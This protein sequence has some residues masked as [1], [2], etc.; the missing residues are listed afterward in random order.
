MSLLFEKNLKWLKRFNDQGGLLVAGTDPTGAG[1][2]IAGYANQRTVEILVEAG[3]SVAEAIKICTLNGAV[4]LEKQDEIGTLEKGK[5]ADLILLHGDLTKNIRN[6][7]NME[8][9]F[10]EGVGFDSV[11]L[12]KSVQGKVGLH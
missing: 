10:K 12:F 2:T 8:I 7:R 1:R 11:K 4:F 9:V 3:F 6:I 5:K